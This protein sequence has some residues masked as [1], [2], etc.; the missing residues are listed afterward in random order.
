MGPGL[1]EY[2]LVYTPTGPLPTIEGRGDFPSGAELERLKHV[3]CAAIPDSRTRLSW[4]G[5]THVRVKPMWIRYSDF[6]SEPPVIT[7]RVF[8]PVSIRVVAGGADPVHCADLVSPLS[9]AHVNR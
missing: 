3:Y 8:T 7:E 6:S 9:V 2:H 1:H 5:I 4:P